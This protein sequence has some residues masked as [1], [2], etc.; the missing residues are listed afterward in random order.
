MVGYDEHGKQAEDQ[1]P[2]IVMHLLQGNQTEEEMKTF[3]TC[4]TEQM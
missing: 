1:L 2:Q 3:L 4:I